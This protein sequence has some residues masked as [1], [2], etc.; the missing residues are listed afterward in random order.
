MFI[1]YSKLYFIYYISDISFSDCLFVV[2]RRCIIHFSFGYSTY[3]DFG[4]GS[5]DFGSCFE[6]SGYCRRVLQMN[7]TDLDRSAAAGLRTHLSVH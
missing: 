5:I 3:L 7:Q 1:N 4:L 6:V 2:L